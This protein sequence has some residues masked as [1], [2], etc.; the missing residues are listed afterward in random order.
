MKVIIA[1]FEISKYGGIVEH[2]ESKA[3]AFKFLG[4]E[5]DL[6]QLSPS[7]VKQRTYDKSIEEFESGTYGSKQ[8]INS[9]NGGYEKSE[10]TGYW[11]N[12]YYGYYLPPS[13]KIGVFE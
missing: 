3:K 12:N 11:K 6:V 9:Q 1:D 2:V 8:K 4:H 7:S 10:S 5:V 13:N